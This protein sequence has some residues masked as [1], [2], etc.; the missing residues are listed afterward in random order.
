MGSSPRLQDLFERDHGGR[1]QSRLL[2]RSAYAI[3]GRDLLQ[4]KTNDR[5]IRFLAGLVK[6][7]ISLTRNG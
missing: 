1:D 3:M 6:N 5:E 2:F 4:T 7:S